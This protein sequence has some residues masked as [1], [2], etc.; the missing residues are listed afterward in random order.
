M[1]NKQKPP[2]NA[3]AV[4]WPDLEALNAH[5]EQMGRVVNDLKRQENAAFVRR[6]LNDLDSAKYALE[7]ASPELIAAL[8][9]ANKSLRGI[10]KS[11]KIADKHVA[12]KIGKSGAWLS[13]CGLPTESSPA[14]KPQTVQARLE[15]LIEARRKALNDLLGTN[16]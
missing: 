10:C 11:C 4:N 5:I 15:L 14:R 6:V 8:S 16:F 3:K 9:S 13:E 2:S 7:P 12:A 1:S